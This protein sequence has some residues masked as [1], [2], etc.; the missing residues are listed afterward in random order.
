M[1]AT[2]IGN[3]VHLTDV[4]RTYDISKVPGELTRT[5][6]WPTRGHSEPTI[7]LSSFMF[8]LSLEHQLQ[9]LAK[10]ADEGRGTPKPKPCMANCGEVEGNTKSELRS[11]TEELVGW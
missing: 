7:A 8:Y 3:S 10:R 4:M 6:V 1:K 11:Y 5:G 9:L 2:N